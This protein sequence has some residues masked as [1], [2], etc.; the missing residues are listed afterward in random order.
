MAK[1]LITGAGGFVGQSLCAAMRERGTEFVPVLR[2][3]LPSQPQAHIVAEIGPATDWLGCLTDVQVVVHL[4]A[5]VHKL[6]DGSGD[7]LSQYRR[8]NVDASLNLARQ[9]VQAGVTR[10]IYLS[11]VKVNGEFTSQRPF[12]ADDAPAPRDAYGIS[13]C[14]AEQGLRRLAQEP[15]LEL[16]VIRPPLVYGPGVKANFLALM[17][18]VARGLPL[19]LASVRHNRR[20][21][22]FVG[23]LVDL[24]LHCME[25][26]TAAG[27]T[28]MASDAHDVS[29]AELIGALAKAMGR[30]HVLFPVPPAL[31]R[32]VARLLG[33]QGAAERLLSSLQVDIQSTEKILGWRP[34]YSFEVGIART[35]QHFLE[36]RGTGQ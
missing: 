12:F 8:M 1:V 6:A 17:R 21:L 26:D 5:R 11:S 27:Q 25:A 35:V 9:C 28:F 31:L 30:R 32:V 36:G 15:G 2:T 19:P 16:V 23:N 3:P 24:I 18:M 10:F 34:P 4:A 13:K 14:E 33:K 29:T 20:S 22:V 7:Y